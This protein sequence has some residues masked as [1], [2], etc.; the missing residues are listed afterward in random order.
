MVEERRSH[1]R[2]GKENGQLVLKR[3]AGSGER[4]LNARCGRGCRACDGLWA[5]FWLFGG[6]VIGF[7]V[8]K[9]LLPPRLRSSACG[10]HVVDFFHLV[11][12]SVAAKQLKGHSSEYYL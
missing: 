11:A 2:A 4:F 6:D 5:P 10:Q 7:S 1:C 8:A 3:P 12:V 9:P